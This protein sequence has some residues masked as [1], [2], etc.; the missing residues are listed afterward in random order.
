VSKFWTGT[1]IGPKSLRRVCPNLSDNES[2][3]LAR[4]LG[5][6]MARFG[7]TTKR[8]ATMF[9]AQVAHE[10]GEFRYREEIASGDAYEGRKDLGNI[11]P[12]DGRRYKG[13]G[14]IQLTGRNN[15]KLAGQE[16]HQDYLSRPSKI[17]RYRTHSARVS[18]WFWRHAGLN[19]ISEEGTALSAFY[20]VTRR[21][22]GGYNGMASRLKY[23]ARARTVA[24]HLMPKVRTIELPEGFEVTPVK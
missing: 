21:I 7:I 4:I 22:N 6:E 17:S 11:W 1:C 23:Y 16:L 15:Y 10:S 2:I 12:G 14:Y 5:K 24:K 13:R 20:K 3:I 18:C 8:R 19:Q 9:I